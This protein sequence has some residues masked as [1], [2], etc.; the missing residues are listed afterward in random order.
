MLKV[1]EVSTQLGISIRAVYDLLH[2][3]RLQYYRLGPRLLRVSQADLDAF[4]EQCRVTPKSKKSVGAPR[5]TVTLKASDIDLRNSFL[6][7]GVKLKPAPA[8]HEG[9]RRKRKAA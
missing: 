2:S 8:V 1:R 3:G 9:A 6:R 5:L 7:H 4:K